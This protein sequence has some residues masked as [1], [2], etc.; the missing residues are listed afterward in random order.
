MLEFRTLY[1]LDVFFGCGG[2][3]RGFGINRAKHRCDKSY[4]FQRGGLSLRWRKM[5]PILL[6][7]DIFLY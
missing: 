3:L 4:S 2:E 6:H 1:M 7:S 5:K